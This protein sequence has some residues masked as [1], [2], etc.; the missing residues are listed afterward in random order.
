MGGMVLVLEGLL[1]VE[2]R[3]AVG[4]EDVAAMVKAL[5]LQLLFRMKMSATKL[6]LMDIIVDQLILIVQYEKAMYDVLCMM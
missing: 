3:S 6:L 4:V 5:Q 2:E 1:M